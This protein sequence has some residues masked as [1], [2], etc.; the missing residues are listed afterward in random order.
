MGEE[1]EKKKTNKKMMKKKK[2]TNKKT[3]NEIKDKE[4]QQQEHYEKKRKKNQEKEQPLTSCS[5]TILYTQGL[6]LMEHSKYTSSP[7]SMLLRLRERPGCRVA[8]GMSE[9]EGEGLGR[10]EHGAGQEHACYLKKLIREE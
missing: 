9:G 1:E 4:Q 5:Q 3:K 7:S 8:R 6:A 10:G 2:K